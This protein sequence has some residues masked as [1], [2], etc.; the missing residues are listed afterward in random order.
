MIRPLQGAGGHH[1]SPEMAHA[2]MFQM[3]NIIQIRE[4]NIPTDRPSPHANE[5]V[6]VQGMPILVG[7]I[8]A[9]ALSRRL[10][11]SKARGINDLFSGLFEDRK[12]V[13]TGAN[14]VSLGA[15]ET[16]VK[17]IGFKDVGPPGG[18]MKLR[19]WFFDGIAEKAFDLPVSS[20]HLKS[21]WQAEG[22]DGLNALKNGCCRAHIRV[23]LA[24][25]LD[26]DDRCYAM[27]N[28][29]LFF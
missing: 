12:F 23:G 26:S 24:M 20:R 27:V 5:D 18:P 2:G 13:R 3:G 17:Q 6:I 22:L 7:Q 9:S 25:A 11:A 1:W 10:E 16:G 21:I 28:N 15:V 29:V 19:A 8:P 4:S 14:C